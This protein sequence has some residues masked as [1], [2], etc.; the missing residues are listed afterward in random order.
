MAT[1]CVAVK[2]ALAER[3]GHRP[4]KHAT[5]ADWHHHTIRIGPEGPAPKRDRTTRGHALATLV[6]AFSQTNTPVVA[7]GCA[8]ART[9]ASH[10]KSR[11]SN[12]ARGEVCLF[13][14]SKTTTVRG[15]S[16]AGIS[17]GAAT[18]GAR[19]GRGSESSPLECNA[20]SHLTS[21]TCCVP[22][23]ADRSRQAAPVLRSTIDRGQR[24]RYCT[25]PTQPAAN[26]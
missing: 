19:G 6:D 7:V 14:S 10:R 17:S 16:N 1:P 11:S 18:R 9:V 15:C 24:P 20:V 5:T 13:I 23:P 3:A 25:L 26:L 22:R 21:C 12:V 8:S 4:R 2:L